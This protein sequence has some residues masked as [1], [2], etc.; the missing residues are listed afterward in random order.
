[1]RPLKLIMSAFGPYAGRV[2]VD[3]DSLGERGIYLITGDTGAGKTTV[4]DAVTFALYGEASGENREA[5]M[6]RSK[7]A[8]ESTPTEVELFFTYGG[9]EYYVKRNP[10]YHRPK[11]RGEGTTIE[12]AN[13]ELQYP[14]GRII[15][16]LTDVNSAIV[17]IMG[18]DR[19]QFTRIAMI[20]QGDF[21]KLLLASTDDRKKIFQ[22]LFKTQNYWLVQEKLKAESS[23]LSR[24]HEAIS[25][26]ISQYI[27]GIVCSEDDAF[28][29]RV[30]KAKDNE[31]PI[32]EII[33]LLE[34]LTDN[35][36]EKEEICNSEIKN[37]DSKILEITKILA[38]AEALSKASQSLK[39]AK[40]DLENAS[41]LREKLLLTLNEE[42]EKTTETDEIIKRMAAIDAHLPLYDELEKNTNE[43][44]SLGDVLAKDKDDLDFKN[45]ELERIT[46][47]IQELENEGKALENTGADKAKI[48]SE[49]KEHTVIKQALENITKEADELA[50]LQKRLSDA[51]MHYLKMSDEAKKQKAIYDSLNKAYLDEQAGILA[52]FLSDGNPCPVC[53][54]LSHPSPAGKSADAPTKEE[55]EEAK[56]AS[57][58]AHEAENSA[59]L[60][61]GQLKG[62]YAQ[63][64]ESVEKL[65]KEFLGDAGIDEKTAE[66]QSLLTKLKE[67][68]SALEKDE[69][70]KSEIEGLL[71][72]GRK[73]LEDV[74]KD[75]GI[76]SEKIAGNTAKS[77]ALSLRIKDEKNNLMYESK[78]EATS[79]RADLEARKNVLEKGL[80]AAMEAF[81]ENEKN[82]A[83]IKSRIAETTKLLENSREI[84]KAAEEEKKNVL[85]NEREEYITLQKQVHSRR[86]ANM[87]SL[88]N[89]INK[90]DEIKTVEEKWMWVKALSNTANGNISGKE[91]IMLETY[92]QMNYFDRIIRRANTRFMVMSSGQY[93][94]KRRTDSLNNRSQSG[95]ELDVIDHYNGSIRSVKTLS[96]GEAFKASL[97]LALGLSDEIQSMSGGIKLDTMFVDE[98]FG[99]LDDESLSQAIRALTSLAEGNRLVGIISHVNELKQRIDKQIVVTKEK[100]GGSKI[101][102]ING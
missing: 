47:K 44:S 64:K 8:N 4:F 51:Q 60:D 30:K 70:R 65:S 38:E 69:K 96:G 83:A 7:Y 36:K 22:K 32:D 98:G 57:D 76:L 9:K 89:I 77:E 14:D 27:Q 50:I 13:A 10:E 91:K 80:K 16:K 46:K 40:T 86:N 37:A 100:T 12:R 55:L 75:I 43:L 90:S 6:F 97:S 39:A 24:E 79:A 101:S 1:M 49:I 5:S 21:L 59:S 45:T 11:S 35:D 99:S 58:R 87:F 56:K 72:V 66:I 20:A 95:L 3:F 33:D 52:D 19:N 73:K 48:E 41:L 17:E 28:Y 82:L 54:A 68:L 94:L 29:P 78:K 25:G 88:D 15:T 18:V 92:I 67:K 2:E 93:E 85:E 81:E 31:L 42:K 34:E 53:G 74:K 84:D 102:I 61:A 63:K 71:P 62:S 23:K 26:S